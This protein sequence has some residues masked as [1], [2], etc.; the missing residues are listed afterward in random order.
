[1]VV[2]S[3]CLIIWEEGRWWIWCILLLC[4][5]VVEDEDSPANF[6]CC[7]GTNF[8]LFYLRNRNLAF[9]IQRWI[10]IMLHVS[11]DNT[12]LP[13][14]VCLLVGRRCDCLMCFWASSSSDV[15][16]M[17]FFFWLVDEFQHSDVS[18][19]IT[20]ITLTQ[21]KT[22]NRIYHAYSLADNDYTSLLL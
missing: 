10:L 14:Q 2:G 21:H 8:A 12:C 7:C 16:D 17:V 1:M 19:H 22:S 13:N 3:L 9:L 15:F 11:M 20:F 6:F 18:I 4:F 5:F